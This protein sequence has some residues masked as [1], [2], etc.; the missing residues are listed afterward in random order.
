MPDVCPRC[1]VEGEHHRVVFEDGFGFTCDPENAGRRMG[2]I[3][4]DT[5][6]IYPRDPVPDEASSLGAGETVVWSEGQRMDCDRR[7][8]VGEDDDD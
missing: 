7:A 8:I 3:D 2:R 4:L 1:G 5:G 6:L